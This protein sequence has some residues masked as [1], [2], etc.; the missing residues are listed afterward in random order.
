M[1]IFT[2]T[3]LAHLRKLVVD[4]IFKEEY[5]K[6]YVNVYDE[7]TA[8]HTPHPMRP[9]VS[10][11]NSCCQSFRTRVLTST[12]QIMARVQK[13]NLTFVALGASLLSQIRNTTPVKEPD[14]RICKI[15]AWPN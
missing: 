15:G 8:F 14:H 9:K 4:I 10:Q 13:Y 1:L 6:K 11:N 3:V 2:S 5:R 12:S 7:W